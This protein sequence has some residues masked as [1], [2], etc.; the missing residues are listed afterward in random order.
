MKEFGIV[1]W[2][3]DRANDGKYG[4]IESPKFE[5]IFFHKSSLDSGTIEQ[6]LSENTVV[7]FV[8]IPSQKHEEKW[9]AT[10]VSLFNQ[11]TDSELLVNLFFD[12]FLDQYLQKYFSQYLKGLYLQLKKTLHHYRHDE[13]IQVYYKAFENAINNFLLERNEISKFEVG[14]I[15]EIGLSLFPDYDEKTFGLFDKRVSSE[16]HF[17]FWEKKLTEVFPYYFF[18]SKKALLDLNYI[19]SV[20]KKSKT[21]DIIELTRRHFDLFIEE[22]PV[23]YPKIKRTLENAKALLNQFF[24]DAMFSISL[25]ITPEIEFRLWRD[26][27]TEI[28]SIDS[29][30][31]N[32]DPSDIE[33]I[34]FCF[35]NTSDEKRKELLI[36]FHQSA[37]IQ[38]S[39]KNI[40]F[41]TIKE[42]YSKAINFFP[43]E[44]LS[45]LIET[46]NNVFENSE[47]IQLWLRGFNKKTP[48]GTI[49]KEISYL[50][51]E[52]TKQ[53]FSKAAIEDI[54]A[55]IRGI[56]FSHWGETSEEKIKDILL[57]SK[58]YVKA[59]NGIFDQQLI[60]EIY[61]SS[62][63]S[64]RLQLWLSN[65]HEI[66][67]FDSYK[68]Y[69]I[70]LPTIFQ[71]E[72]LKK[73][74]SY[75]HSEKVE[76]SIEDLT[77]LNVI[78][79]NTS[80]IA[81]D[82]DG[83]PLDYSISILLYLLKTLHEQIK[84]ENKY[85]VKKKLFEIILNQIEDPKDILEISGFFDK[86][87]GRSITE[88]YIDSAGETQY[89]IVRK[90]E[91]KPPYH[92]VC[93]GR[94]AKEKNT[95]KPTKDENSGFEFWWCANQK[96]F[97]P[98]QNFKDV[99]NWRKYAIQDFLRILNIQYNEADLEVYLSTINKVN[100]FL[101]HLKCRDCKNILYPTGQ[102][103]F[104]IH[105]VNNFNCVNES[106][107]EKGKEIYITHCLNGRCDGTIDSR[108]SVKCKPDGYGQDS[109]GWYV[110]NDCHACC[111]T[112]KLN[113]RKYVAEVINKVQYKC[114]HQG[115]VN[116]GQICCNNCG[117]VMNTF[118]PNVE[119]FNR[120]LDWFVKN[121]DTSKHIVKYG[122]NKFEK[123]WF[124]LKA[125]DGDG[126]TFFKRLLHYKRVGFNVPEL[127]E[128]NMFQ[129][130]SEPINF[131][132]IKVNELECGNCGNRIDMNEFPEKKLIMKGY[133]ERVP[134]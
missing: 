5:S 43:A 76:I 53:I 56:L 74:L 71:K 121:K 51:K 106:C 41:N 81:E 24:V 16:D 8:A 48:L 101:E 63:V 55:I 65:F 57:V 3:H 70:T 78:D 58:S 66:L 29:I 60:K 33:L 130:I 96:C 59:K 98:C 36:L 110:C 42:F 50:E 35:K 14:S 54:H 99:V 83:K 68:H 119:E 133:H 116:L 108:D 28:C 6:N 77:S 118:E 122:K 112:E 91:L 95:G 93:D 19:K 87:E 104:A 31:R 72:F 82:I 64:L 113:G 124:R 134:L 79:Y 127:V 62:S 40:S 23:D 37:I 26:K 27:V 105:G 25:S 84:V 45:E 39:E 73:V 7:S 17:Y 49:V 131:G 125:K 20:A 88:K 75:I 4:F 2:Y 126:E 94:K 129:M 38:F 10:E 86:C 46:S 1:K 114:H 34:E 69:L 132:E 89:K 61:D 9:E 80:K 103:N 67:D 102:S 107:G 100:R 15:L 13:S 12:S 111:N 32:Y 85:E 44:L 18:L 128:G 123:W 11:R 109:C 90:E 22:K 92:S 97:S 117:H 115:H 47:K 52:L 21:S 120:I 30:M